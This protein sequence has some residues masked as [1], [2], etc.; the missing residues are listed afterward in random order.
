MCMVSLAHLF[1]EKYI[2]FSQYNTI[3]MTQNIVAVKIL[4]QIGFM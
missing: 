3:L 1:Y 4:I 2:V